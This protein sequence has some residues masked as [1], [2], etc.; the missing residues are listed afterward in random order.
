MMG[1]ITHPGRPHS[2]RGKSAL[3]W[4]MA[5]AFVLSVTAWTPDLLA[6]PGGMAWF[7]VALALIC[8]VLASGTAKLQP[9]LDSTQERL[10]RGIF[11]IASAIAFWAVLTSFQAEDPLRVGRPVAAFLAG[12]L[13]FFA[14]NR[15][16]PPY[17]I[18]RLIDWNIYLAVLGAL[19]SF[20]ALYLPALGQVFYE[21][22]DRTQAFFNHPNQFAIALS[23]IAPVVAAKILSSSKHRVRWAA[24]LLAVILGFVLAG[25]KANTLVTLGALFLLALF[26]AIT[27]RSAI[28]SVFF[29]VFSIV[30]GAVA[31][32]VAW[33]LVLTF[34]PRMA[35]LLESLASGEGIASVNGRYLIWDLSLEAFYADPLFGQGGGAM[36]TRTFQSDALTQSHNVILDMARTLGVPGLVAIGVFTLL[37]VAVCSYQFLLAIKLRAV[38]RNE[39]MVLVGLALG[40]LSYF[41]ANMSSDSFGPSTS[42]VFWTIFTISLWQ[43]RKVLAFAQDAAMRGRPSR[44]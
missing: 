17:R 24:I 11:F 32:Y 37:L 19:F 14:L 39:R 22:R 2:A 18:D 36:L 35:K 5:G 44:P 29:L 9:P 38:D 42:P 4:G 25:S 43:G 28:R 21:G 40:S 12:P 23:T 13:L 3:G 1:A 16:V 15:L 41:V 26:G 8:C 6:P 31:L 10:A 30:A 34:N 20:A 33:E 27:H 7:H